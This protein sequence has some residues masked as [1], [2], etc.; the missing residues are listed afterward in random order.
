[1]CCST[2]TS[3]QAK[4]VLV[5]TNAFLHYFMGALQI[6]SIKN[7]RITTIPYRTTRPSY[8]LEL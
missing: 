7:L 4:Y 3:T 2:T 5:N 6:Y 1:M 8:G